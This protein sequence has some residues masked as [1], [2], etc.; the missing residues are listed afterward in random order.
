[1]SPPKV[2]GGAQSSY[3]PIIF[4]CPNCGREIRVRTSAAGQEGTCTD[5]NARLVVPGLT[6]F[7]ANNSPAPS[8]SEIPNGFL[9]DPEAA[10]ATP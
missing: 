3:M 2:N 8:T 9:I 4:F 5:C 7:R 1:M 6:E 10:D